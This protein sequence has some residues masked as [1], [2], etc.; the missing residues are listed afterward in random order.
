[1]WTT[2]NFKD[3]KLKTTARDICKRNLDI[4]FERDLSVDLGA[5]LGDGHRE[6]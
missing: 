6:N 3:R 1:M 5:M 4:K 2:L